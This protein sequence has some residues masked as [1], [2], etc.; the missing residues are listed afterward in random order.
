M[1]RALNFQFEESKVLVLDLLNSTPDSINKGRLINNLAMIE[2]NLFVEENPDMMI[3]DFDM[4]DP[5]LKVIQ[6]LL[7]D[8]E[9]SIFYLE[10][11][12]FYT[13]CGSMK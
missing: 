1:A 12:H 10:G 3:S 9:K 6:K 8:L 5:N 13:F 7:L 11:I 2:F 4:N